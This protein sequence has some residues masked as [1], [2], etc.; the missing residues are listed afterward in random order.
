[1]AIQWTT[2][3]PRPS[4]KDQANKELSGRLGYSPDAIGGMGSIALQGT[5]D[6]AAQDNQYENNAKLSEQNAGQDLISGEQQGAY[7]ILNTLLGKGYISE[8]QKAAALKHLQGLLND[9]GG[10]GLL[11]QQY[12]QTGGVDPATM[13]LMSD[14][15]SNVR[16]KYNALAERG[17]LTTDE[18]SRILNS[19]RN[20]MMR[21]GRNVAESTFNASNPGG[22]PFAASALMAQSAANTGAEMVKQRADLDKYQSDTR[23]K[24]MDGLKGL[25]DS[26]SGVLMEQAGNKSKGLDA[27][28]DLLGIKADAVGEMSDLETRTKPEGDDQYGDVVQKVLGSLSNLVTTKTNKKGKA[29]VSTVYDNK[30]KNSDSGSKGFW[31]G[32]R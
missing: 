1:M 17:G 20:D 5:M 10:A 18:Y 31:G 28:R 22:S 11:A 13:Q 23:I 30:K 32:F 15:Y 29:S 25:F 7:Q 9:V 8:G 6:Q 14:E 12:A 24:G 21:Q 3:D 16:G 19:G 26:G 27:I 4:G 2:P